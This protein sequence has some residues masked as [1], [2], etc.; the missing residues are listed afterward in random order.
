MLQLFRSFFQS[1]LGIIVTL[2]F[3]ALIALAFAS[4]DVANTGTFGGITGGDRVAVVGDRRVD[5]AELSMNASNAFERARQEDPTLTMQVFAA[6][7]GVDGILEQM[8]SR[9][10]LAAFG[11]EHGMRAGKRLVDS[12]IRQI[13]AFRDLSGNFSQEIY[14]G[15]LRQQGLTDA[16]VREDLAMGLFAR[17]VVTPLALGPTMPT[18]LSQRYAQLL[19]ETREGAVALLPS[20]AFMP[21][22]APTA[23]QLQTYYQENRSGYVRPERR[24]IRYAVFGEDA[25]GEQAAPTQAQIAARYQRDQAQYAQQED[26]TFTQLVVPTQAAAQAIVD[27]VR[28]GVSLQQSAQQKGLATV[29]I[30]P[31]SR[32]DLAQRTSAAVAQAGFAAARGALSAPAQG[33]LGWYVL[34]VEALDTRAGRSLAQVRNDIAQTLAVE[35]R[36]AA[37]GDLTVRIEEELEDGRNLT[38]L[39][40]E[41]G[42]ALQQTPPL[43]AVGQVYGSEG[44]VPAELA[45]VVQAAFEMDEEEPQLAVLQPGQQFLVYDVTDITQSA[46]AP[47]AEIREQVVAAWRRDRGFAGAREAATRIMRRVAGGQPLA[48]AARAEKAQLPPVDDVSLN[49]QQISQQGQVPPVLALLFSMAEGTVKRLAAP[50]NTGWF[51]VA[52]DDIVTPDLA[53]DDPIVAATGQQLQSVLGDEYVEQFVRAVQQEVGVERNQ[54]GIDAVVAQLTGQAN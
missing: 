9:V 44:T 18:S 43:T 51:V 16:A 21:A 54:A 20:T 45:P 6:N 14:Q 41:L 32:G 49:R 48:E 52:L 36:S 13:P 39:A 31:I 7:G 3:L 15:A 8:L 50:E 38:E 25:L 29:Q 24:V 1:K 22:G 27:E 2:A 37:L 47:L 53:N 12:E 11:E 19:R 5:T 4:T 34:Q 35:Q 30:G 26:R 42:L 28:G 46:T 17:Q 23:A 40:E 10:A 33:G